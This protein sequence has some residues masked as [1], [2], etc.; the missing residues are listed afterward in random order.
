MLVDEERWQSGLLRRVAIALTGK[1]VRG[2]K[3]L[4]FLQT[5]HTTGGWQSGLLQQS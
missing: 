5:H 4:S 3:S 1:P 2:F